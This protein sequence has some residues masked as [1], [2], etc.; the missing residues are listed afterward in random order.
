MQP[1]LRSVSAPKVNPSDAA[2]RSHCIAQFHAQ[3]ACARGSQAG[4]RQRL[5]RGESC[6]DKQ[7]QRRSAAGIM[8]D[9]AGGEQAHYHA[10]CRST[11]VRGEDGDDKAHWSRRSTTK[12]GEVNERSPVPAIERQRGRNVA[13]GDA[14]VRRPVCVTPGWVHQRLI[15]AEVRRSNGRFV[16]LPNNYGVRA[17]VPSMT[18]LRYR[19]PA[20]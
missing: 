16:P 18:P 3:P 6:S 5:W 13:I 11:K 20:C 10:A 15:E 12:F 7:G 14:F 17:T 2:A 4:S 1:P 19:H 9:D 8:G